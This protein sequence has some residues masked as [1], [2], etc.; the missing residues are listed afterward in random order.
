MR[1][2]LLLA[3]ASC[4]AAPAAETQSS[5]VNAAPTALAGEYRFRGEVKPLKRL[6]VDVIDVRMPGAAE[7]LEAVR[8]DGA[9]CERPLANV[10]RCTTHR[11]AAAVPPESLAKI[12]A[13][14]EGDHATFGAVTAPPSLVNDSES[15]IEWEIFQEGGTHAGTF[16]RYVYRVLAGRLSKAALGEVEVIV[17]DAA[18]LSRF[19]SVTVNESRWRWHVDS[20]LVGLT[21]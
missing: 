21:R 14:S 4:A 2:L 20:A 11:D 3:L 18:H 12:A 8:R 15:L 1:S 7:R 9:T 19:A 6:T 17:D 5:E 13:R 16:E 10:Y